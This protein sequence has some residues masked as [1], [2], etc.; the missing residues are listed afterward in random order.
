MAKRLKLKT[1]NKR[2]LSFEIKFF[3]VALILNLLFF[4][5]KKMLIKF[6]RRMDIYDEGFNRNIKIFPKY[7]FYL[8]KIMLVF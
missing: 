7:Q 1:I 3:F 5:I 8:I 4:K 6:R 2:T